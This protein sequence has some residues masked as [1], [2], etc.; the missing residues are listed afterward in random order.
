MYAGLL[1]IWVTRLRVGHE[2][3]CP[4]QSPP[5]RQRPR[6]R[7]RV[8][9]RRR[10]RP[11]HGGCLGPSIRP[12]HLGSR[13]AGTAVTVLSWPGD[14]L[15]IHVAVEQCRPGDASSTAHHDRRGRPVSRTGA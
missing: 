1:I 6:G 14:N 8:A 15:M 13:I 11:G 7:L 2:Y 9:R 4:L 10:D 12:V 5:R 3:Y